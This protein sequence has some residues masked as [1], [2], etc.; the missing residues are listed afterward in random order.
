M[1][2]VIIEIYPWC[3]DTREAAINS[4]LGVGA[5]NGEAKMESKSFT[6]N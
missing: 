5:R 6:K 2:K 4:D 1:V 3:G